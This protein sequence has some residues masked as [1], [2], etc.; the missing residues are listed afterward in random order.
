MKTKNISCVCCTQYCKNKN[1]Q[2]LIK[3]LKA[4]EKEGVEEIIFN[5]Q[6]L[7]G[8]IKKISEKLKARVGHKDIKNNIKYF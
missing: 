5:C 6:S 1:E 3:V 4:L 7:N 8:S 2:K